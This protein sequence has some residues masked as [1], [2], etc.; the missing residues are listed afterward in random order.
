[1]PHPLRFYDSL[2]RPIEG[3]DLSPPEPTTHPGATHPGDADTPVRCQTGDTFERFTDRSRRVLVLAQEEARLLSHSFI[4][5]EHLLLGLISEGEGVAATALAS[6]GVTL[7]AVRE[8]V[9]ET[10]G[11]VSTTP[12][13]SLP[14]TPRAK[15]V[16]ELALREALQLGHSYIGT[17][18]LLLGLV[19]EGE[20]VAS[21]ILV[22]LGVDLGRV[23]WEVIRLV[24]GP[25]AG[26]AEETPGL[27]A[28][29]V[30]SRPTSRTLGRP[31]VERHVLAVG[32]R[33]SAEVVRAG[34]GP[35]DFASAYDQ[36]AELAIRLGLDDLDASRLQLSSVETDDGPGL[37]LAVTHELGA[38]SG[39]EGGAARGGA[40]PAESRSGPSA[41]SEREVTGEGCDDDEDGAVGSS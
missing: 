17:E 34:R 24:G 40:G 14:F 11:T 32:R 18:H 25:A 16:L 35:Q 15:K 5:T 26:G 22:S 38:G 27:P 19:R 36:L 23:H 2:I 28:S 20:G 39:A 8:K 1:M 12:T 29:A 6:V 7:T 10:M 31:S 3:P 33:W 21:Q 41:A 9:R 13:G 4:G 30:S 37:R